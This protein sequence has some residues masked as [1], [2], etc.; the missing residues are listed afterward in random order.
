M[1]GFLEEKQ[2]KQNAQRYARFKFCGAAAFWLLLWQ[3][4]AEWTDNDILIVGPLQ[5]F[6]ALGGLAVQAE[7]WRSVLNSFLRIGTGFLFAALLGIVLG[8]AAYKSSLLRQFLAPPVALMKSIPVA[9]F[10]ILAIIWLGG[11]ENLSVFVSVVVVFPM[12]YL[13]TI[14][15]L[16]STDRR[17]LEMAQVFELAF[18]KKWRF[19]YLPALLPYL[20][21][22]FRTSLG[23]AWRSGVAAEL[24]GQ[25]VHTIGGNLYQAKIFLDTP[26]LFAWTFTIIAISLLFEQAVL[27]LLGRLSAEERHGAEE[28]SA[29]ERT[30]HVSGNTVQKGAVTVQTDEKA[31]ASALSNRIQN[32]EN[33]ESAAQEGRSGPET[34]AAVPWTVRWN[35]ISKS[36]GGTAVLRGFC[37]SM[38]APYSYA[39]SGESGS[40]KTTFLRML[41]GLERPDSGKIEWLGE[42]EETAPPRCAAV[43]QEDR[44]CEAFSA[45]ENIRLCMQRGAELS[46]EEIRQELLEVL[47]A[48]CLNKP[49]GKLSGGQKRRVAIVRAMCAPRAQAIFMDEPFTGL[50]EETKQLVIRYVLSR[51]RGRILLLATHDEGEREALLI[52]RERVFFVEA[53]DR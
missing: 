10:V 20:L 31:F 15:G 28:A 49:C 46:R 35:G 33:A 25:P 21:S 51:K 9:S 23:M 30:A 36:F 32:S 7:F 43:F 29:A 24:I 5:M 16:M 52:S 44:L 11:T 6:A 4:A 39:L 17:L 8:A 22:C 3:L 48:D 14:G 18:W 34:E 2:K 40:G 1:K 47:P 38:E 41:M 27:R 37:G 53:A 26:A 42:A 19:I 45:A 50:D 12:V 13:S